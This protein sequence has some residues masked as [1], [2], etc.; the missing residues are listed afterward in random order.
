MG[1]SV[2]C[3][4][5]HCPWLVLSNTIHLQAGR[6][7]SR[8]ALLPLASR[9]RKC[10]AASGQMPGTPWALAPTGYHGML[11]GSLQPVFY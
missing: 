10:S 8:K 5:Y 2:L 6:G 11:T 3:T 4:R 1:D 9:P 7:H